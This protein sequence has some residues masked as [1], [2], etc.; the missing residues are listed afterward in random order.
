VVIWA[1]KSFSLPRPGGEVAA[2]LPQHEPSLNGPSIEPD[3]D[4]FTALARILFD[5]PRMLV[6]LTEEQG[7]EGSG[8]D[9]TVPAPVAPLDPLLKK[10]LLSTNHQRFCFRAAVPLCTREGRQ[11]GTLHVAAP[12]PRPRHRKGEPDRRRMEVLAN[13]AADLLE[14]RVHLRRA[15]EMLHEKD[16]LAREA[17]HR[18]AN[19]LQLL[20]GTLTLQAKGELQ[21][22]SRT[23]LQAA[24]RRVA[25]VAE[26]HRHL[27]RIP[28]MLPAGG[29]ANAEGYL[30]VLL[31]EFGPLPRADG[32]TG[33]AGRSVVLE[34]EPGAA[35]AVAADLLPR[36]GLITAELVANAL[37]HGAGRV[38]VELRRA[39][40]VDSDGIVL[41]VSDEGSGFPTG[42]APEQRG[43]AGLGMRLVAALSG[44]GGVW[45]DPADRRR[46]LV[47][48]VDLNRPRFAGGQ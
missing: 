25:A 8:P 23:A 42:F 15:S 21:A 47:R 44:P 17:D 13:A 24:A 48:L 14:A 33:A 40:L 20:H 16:L 32:D 26:A 2:H 38:L 1:N 4:R 45:L 36:L 30:A 7:G 28:D 3:P 39:T 35:A 5:A 41:A 22:T 10:A 29:A 46:I 37:K 12:E 6:W 34:T 27:H 11:I 9:E 19:G 43:R 31:K 18:V